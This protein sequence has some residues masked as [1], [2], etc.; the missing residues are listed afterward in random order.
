M[1]LS[2][3]DCDDPTFYITDNFL[4]FSNSMK[5]SNLVGGLLTFFH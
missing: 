5:T 3:Y 4:A 1:L 2:K